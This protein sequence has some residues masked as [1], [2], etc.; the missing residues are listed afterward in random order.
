MKFLFANVQPFVGYHFTIISSSLASR[1]TMGSSIQR[2]TH[3]SLVP[4]F[5]PNAAV[6]MSPDNQQPPL[7]I[8]PPPKPPANWNFALTLF[9]FASWTIPLIFILIH[10]SNLTLELGQARREAADLK[11]ANLATPDPVTT[12]VV[13]TFTATTTSV[14]TSTTVLTVGNKWFFAGDSS[15]ASSEPTHLPWE[16]V[17]DPPPSYTI[18]PSATPSPTQTD[19]KDGMAS[20]NPSPWSSVHLDL[21]STREMTEHLR[22]AI[23][24]LW[25]VV[26]KVWNY[27]LDPP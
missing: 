2:L 24:G 17:D 10:M 23:V 19:S 5:Y 21:P 26:L 18:T 12:T 15:S 7:L 8:E 1:K 20:K 27:P 4:Y 16:S 13:S 9:K 11:E 25:K 14:S 22:W 3:W 6:R